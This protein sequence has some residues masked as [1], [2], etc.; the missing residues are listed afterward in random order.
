MATISTDRALLVYLFPPYSPDLN[1]IEE[2]FSSVKSFLKT[3]QEIVIN[4]DLQ[5]VLLSAFLNITS[6]DT[7]GW[8]RDSGYC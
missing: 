7:A 1:P 5:Q 2:A 6:S 8:Y 4:K 3:N